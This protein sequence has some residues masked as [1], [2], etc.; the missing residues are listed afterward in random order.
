M[1]VDPYCARSDRAANPERAGSILGEDGGRQT[2]GRCVG[3]VNGFCL[4]FKCFKRHDWAEE[5]LLNEGRG[6]VLYTKQGWRQKRPGAV[7]TALQDHATFV[8][9][10]L[11]QPQNALLAGKIN[12]RAH[13]ARRITAA[14]NLYSFIGCGHALFEPLCNA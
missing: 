6:Y 11:N 9:S 14:P 5:F 3:F 8:A 4:V 13:C 7:P 2:I 12:E 1:R 10:L